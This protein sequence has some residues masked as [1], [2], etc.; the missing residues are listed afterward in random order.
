MKCV[1]RI[2]CI[3]VRALLET[4][5]SARLTD[6]RGSYMHFCHFYGIEP[7][8]CLSVIPGMLYCIQT[9]KVRLRMEIND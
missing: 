1:H 8:V 4:R 7:W 5:N 9:Y 2:K 3:K 6:Q